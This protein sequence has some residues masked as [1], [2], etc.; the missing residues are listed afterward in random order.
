MKQILEWNTCK[1]LD[2]EVK[3]LLKNLDC[4]FKNE[5]DARKSF[6]EDSWYWTEQW[7]FLCEELTE[8]MQTITAKNKYTD[9]WIT[10]VQGFGWKNIDGEKTFNAENGKELLQ[11]ILPKTDCTFQIFKERNKLKIRNWHHDSPTGNE[12]YYIKPMTAKEVEK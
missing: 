7:N 3:E 12:Y 11:A 5:D 9:K 1:I 2:R 6:I 8:I 4:D 10:T